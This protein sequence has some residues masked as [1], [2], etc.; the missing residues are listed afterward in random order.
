MATGF[1]PIADRRGSFPGFVDNVPIQDKVR[2]INHELT[3]LKQRIERI[4]RSPDAQSARI[5]ELEESKKE[6][7]KLKSLLQ[8]IQKELKVRDAEIDKLKAKSE[9]DEQKIKELRKEVEELQKTLVEKEKQIER[10][11][12][13]LHVTRKELKDYKKT[14]DQ[15]VDTLA[16]EVNKLTAFITRSF[17]N[18]QATE[19]SDPSAVTGPAG[20]RFPQEHHEEQPPPLQRP[21]QSQQ[22]PQQSSPQP[23]QPQ[24]K[25]SQGLPGTSGG[26]HGRSD[27]PPRTSKSSLECHHSPQR[28]RLQKQKDQAS[29]QPNT[30]RATPRVGTFPINGPGDQPHSRFLPGQKKV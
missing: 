7:T 23:Q 1:P 30:P 4:E 12:E 18:V 22:Q 5:K 27:Q 21:Q 11:Q 13:E 24:I 10:L 14:N 20:Q 29:A 17:Q 8:E 6:V 3:V 15:K 9:D 19:P 25:P 26:H 16:E 2:H 28:D